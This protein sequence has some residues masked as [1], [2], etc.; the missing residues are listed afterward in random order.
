MNK[1]ISIILCINFI[2]SV[3][4]Y[5]DLKNYNKEI[6]E[7]IENIYFFEMQAPSKKWLPIW[8]EKEFQPDHS[9]D[10]N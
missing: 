2:F 3:F 6:Y 4:L 1:F 7:L 5:I 8:L 10:R 9:K